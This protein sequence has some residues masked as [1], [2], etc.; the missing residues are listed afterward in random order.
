MSLTI[1]DQSL[2]KAEEMMKK[3]AYNDAEIKIVKEA[4]LCHSCKDKLPKTKEGKALATADAMA[5]MMTDF[6][7]IMFFKRWLKA[8]KTYE[9]YR[10]WVLKKIERDF[11][12]KM[13][14]P[15]YR[16]KSKKRYEAIKTLFSVA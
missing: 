6:Y 4:I 14:Y 15:E 3:Y 8:A 13:F 5:H 12:T 10:I 7:L 1:I 2:A 16:R 9:E 11:Y